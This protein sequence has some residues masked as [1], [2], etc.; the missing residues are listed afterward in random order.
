VAEKLS[1]AWTG[2]VKRPQLEEYSARYRDFFVMER[3]GGII[4]VRMH[5]DGGPFVTTMAGHNALGQAWLEIGNDPENQV[6]IITGTGDQWMVTDIP[7]HLR[8]L[9]DDRSPDEH[10]KGF[11]D[12]RKILENLV[13][14]IDVP[15]IAAINAPG[16]HTELALAC[17][18]TLC[19]RDAVMFDAH[20]AAGIAPGDGQGLAF[21]ELM[22]SKRAAYYL[23]AGAMIE[24]STALQLGLVNE[25]L[26]R[27][28]LLPRAWE[29]AEMIMRRPVNARRM[30]HAIVVRPWKRRLADDLGFHLGHELVGILADG[31]G[32]GASQPLSTTP[33]DRP[34]A[35]D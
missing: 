16:A 14:C 32:A 15:T 29:L 17:D 22:G 9:E 12:A 7:A 35:Y 26:A 13:F 10:A 18:I 27:D 21:Q 1:G 33:E 5:T 24:A 25:V 34:N 19:S 8:A 20:F 28:D 23:Y 31:A 2:L 3:R 11:Y 4:E 30:T 6:V